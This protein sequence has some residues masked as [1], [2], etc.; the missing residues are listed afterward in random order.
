MEIRSV[1]IRLSAPPQVPGPHRLLHDRWWGGRDRSAPVQRL[2]PWLIRQAA[3]PGHG[4][5]SASTPGR[6]LKQHLLKP[7]FKSL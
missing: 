5:V 7:S 4:Y 3:L 1:Y 2:P 6:C